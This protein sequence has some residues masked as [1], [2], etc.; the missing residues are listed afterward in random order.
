MNSPDFL[1]VALIVVRG[2]CPSDSEHLGAFVDNVT[3]KAMR[4]ILAGSVAVK[5]V[6]FDPFEGWKGEDIDIVEAIS[7]EAD[8]RVKVTE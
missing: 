8:T 7:A 5:R 1:R 4:G 6:R 3:G 2:E